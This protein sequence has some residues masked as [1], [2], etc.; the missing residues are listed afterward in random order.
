MQHRIVT[1]EDLQK[2]QEELNGR[3]QA[4][5]RTRTILNTQKKRKG[6]LYTALATVEQFSPVADLL[7]EGTVGTA[8]EQ[9]RWKDAQTLLEGQ[10]TEQLGREKAELFQRIADVNRQMR[11]I[12]KELRVCES[13]ARAAP[14]LQEQLRAIRDENSIGGDLHEHEQR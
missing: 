14:Q 13:I 7:S 2:H 4:L 6:K 12:R 11:E 3:L 10:D 9:A 1:G 8:E 5:T